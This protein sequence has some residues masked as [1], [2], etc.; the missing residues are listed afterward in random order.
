M[1]NSAQIAEIGIGTN[2]AGLSLKILR[3]KP[4]KE[5]ANCE[6]APK[7]TLLQNQAILQ[8]A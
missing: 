2:L 7:H 8:R 5:A 6:L 3:P 4:A 1:Y